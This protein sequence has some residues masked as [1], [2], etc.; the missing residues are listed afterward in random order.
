MSCARCYRKH[1]LLHRPDTGIDTRSSAAGRTEAVCEYDLNFL[2][3]VPLGMEVRES[4]DAGGRRYLE[5]GFASNSRVPKGGRRGCATVSIE[6][7]EP[8]LVIM[9]PS[10]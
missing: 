7:D 4:G 1:V 9:S 2:G 8:E 5:S 10:K 3:E 6:A